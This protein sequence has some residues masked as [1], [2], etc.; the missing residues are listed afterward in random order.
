MGPGW[1][2]LGQLFTAADTALATVYWPWL[3]DTA[4]VA[5]SFPR[6]W[7]VYYSTDHDEGTGGIAY[8]EADQ[9]AGPWT[10]HPVVYVDTAAG[11]Q[12]ETPSVVWVPETALWH[13][14]YQQAGIEGGQRS[15]CPAFAGSP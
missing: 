5:G 2:D 13:L 7:R 1:T 6:R 15:S 8:A 14:Y 10:H 9:P 4:T 12:T 11:T 3:V